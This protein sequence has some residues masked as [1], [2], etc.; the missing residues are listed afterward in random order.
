MDA[1]QCIGCGACVAACPNGAA[2]LFVGAKVSHFALLPQGRVE[3]ARRVQAMVEQ[4]DKEGFGNCANE[5]ECEAACPKEISVA[6]IAR[7][8]KEYR[9]SCLSSD[10]A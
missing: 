3:A 1:A 7:M 2:M 10:P 9:N 8:N 5:Y 4:M 6:N